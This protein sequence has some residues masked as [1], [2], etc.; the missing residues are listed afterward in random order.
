MAHYEKVCCPD[1]GCTDLRKYGPRENGTQRWLCK[2][3]R[4]ATRSFQ[5]RY[6]YRAHERG[7]KA[8]IDSQTLDGSGVREISRTLKITKNTVIR[9]LKKKYKP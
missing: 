6:T 1:C 2:N 3:T 9:H 4:C 5:L 7:V 8:Q